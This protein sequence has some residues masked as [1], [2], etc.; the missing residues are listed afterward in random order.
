MHEPKKSTCDDLHFAL[1][2]GSME[3]IHTLI[4]QK[5]DV[6]ELYGEGCSPLL[7]AAFH[8][9]APEVLQ[10]LVDAKAD[11]NLR[12]RFASGTLPNMW[13]ELLQRA[14]AH[15]GLTRDQVVS[16]LVWA[17]LKQSAA[18]VKILIDVKADVNFMNVNL[19]S[20]VFGCGNRLVIS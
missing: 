10:T 8:T 2:H 9:R 15:V 14:E 5:A 19:Q 20:I 4:N 18:N 13:I 1:E 17:T 12:S 11:S 6:N 16:P 7:R 3:E